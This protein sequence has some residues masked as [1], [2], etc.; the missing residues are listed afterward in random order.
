MDIEKSVLPGSVSAKRVPAA[1][2][3]VELAA[4]LA[5]DSEGLVART[6]EKLDSICLSDCTEIGANGA[7]LEEMP[8]YFNELRAAL[9]VI[10]SSLRRLNGIVERVDV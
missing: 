10:Q 9:N 8:P 1:D 7:P 5:K 3:I 6:A 4:R 2:M